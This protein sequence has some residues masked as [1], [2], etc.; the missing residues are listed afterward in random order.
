MAF[1]ISQFKSQMDWFG[2]PDRAS[3][4]EVTL[5]NFPENTS[6]ASGYDLKFFCKNVAIPGMV[7]N[8]AQYEAVGQMRKV[9][10]MGFNPEPIQAIF[11]LDSDK[12]VLTFFHSW[13]Q[14][15]VNYSTAAG[16]FSVV[17][18]ML[19]FEIAYKDDYACRMTIKHFSADYAKTGRYYEVILDKAFPL[20]MGDV[21]LSWENG[22]SFVVLPVSIQYD[23]IQ[24]S[25]EKYG[26]PLGGDGNSLLKLF[27][28]LGA[29]GDVF[30]KQIVPNSV[31]DAVNKFTTVRGT[32]DNISNK[33][34]N[35]NKQLSGIFR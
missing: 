15:M 18:G 23:R 28:A 32:Y 29:V 30:G 17:D 27:G 25:G 6:R 34:G 22:D 24:F 20:Q 8:P 12:Q 14:S 1:N 26:V 19:P 35:L 33:V 3:L 31:Q 16:P 9:Y 10:P 5:S 11:L 4:F 2:G 13:A 7:F 21:D